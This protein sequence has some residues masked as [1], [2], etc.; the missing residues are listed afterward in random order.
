[1]DT[2]RHI[3]LIDELCFRPFPPEH[4]HHLVVLSGSHGLRG[5]GDPAE[6]A[7]A[8]DQYEKERDALD[9][10]LTERWGES[11]ILG[12]QTILLRTGRAEGIPE[13]WAELSARARVA[14]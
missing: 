2:A 6:R 10:R 11:E 8:V 5:G 7:V 12:L 3:A 14:F 1:M 9:A 13:P 4:G